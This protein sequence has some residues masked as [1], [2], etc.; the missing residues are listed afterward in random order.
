MVPEQ[1]SAQSQLPLSVKAVIAFLVI[2]LLLI[3]GMQVVSVVNF[4]L[5]LSLGLQEDDPNS[6]DPF[7][8][9]HAILEQGI[10]GADVIIQGLL[11]I[12][13]IVG[14]LQRRAFGY[15]CAL[16]ELGI[17]IYWPT[18]DIFQESLLVSRG[19]MEGLDVSTVVFETVYIALSLV[20]AL[21]LYRHRRLFLAQ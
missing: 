10:A 11:L 18:F 13:A 12:G 4:E 8:R 21:V 19:L 2:A 16:G 1:T 15:A 20:A 5:A 6:L 17:S 7:I 3:V 14:L 9:G